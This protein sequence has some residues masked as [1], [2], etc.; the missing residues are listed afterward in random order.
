MYKIVP[1][2]TPL[3]ERLQVV[4]PV[5]L[6]VHEETALRVAGASLSEG[7]QSTSH[8]PT[9]GRAQDVSEVAQSPLTDRPQQV[10]LRSS[11]SIPIILSCYDVVETAAVEAVDAARDCGGQRPHLRRVS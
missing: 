5:G 7:H 8:N 6:A 3:C 10:I 2:R 11:G 9:L 1:S 4:E